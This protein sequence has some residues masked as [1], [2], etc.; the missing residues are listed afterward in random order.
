MVTVKISRTKCERNGTKNHSCPIQNKKKLKKV[1]GGSLWAGPCDKREKSK[2]L[3]SRP[4]LDIDRF[5]SCVDMAGW[6]LGQ[7]SLDATGGA[8]R[9]EKDWTVSLPA[10]GTV[11]ATGLL[12]PLLVPSCPSGGSG[13]L[14]WKFTVVLTHTLQVPEDCLVFF[15]SSSLCSSFLPFPSSSWWYHL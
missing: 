13:L 9:W 1:C 14:P 7:G 4:E 2:N 3:K 5:F 10:A 8:Q 12:S 11:L 6:G 15:L